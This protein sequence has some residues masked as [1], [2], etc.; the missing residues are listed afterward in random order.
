MFTLRTFAKIFAAAVC[1]IA[2]GAGFFLYSKR[3][4]LMQDAL[5]FAAEFASKNLGTTVTVGSANLD[6]I[7]LTSFKTS[8]LVLRDIKIF[9]KN[10]EP[11][12][13]VDEARLTFKLLALYYEGAAAID[14]VTVN[15]ARANI[16]KR[17]D[18]SWNFNDIK[19]KSS[20]GSNFDAFV[21]VTDANVHAEF[22]GK[23]VDVE[24]I[25]ATADCSD[26]DAIKTK[27]YATTLGANLDANA[28]LGL[29]RQIVNARV[30]FVD[31]LKILP[32]VP[33][34]II[35]DGVELLAGNVSGVTLN[36]LRTDTLSFSGSANF[37]DAAVNV[38]DTE[39]SNL[40]GTATFTDAQIFFNASAAANGQFADFNGNVRTDT[41]VPF[42][43]IRANSGS[44][45]PSAILAT[46]PIESLF[47]FDAH[48]VGTFDDPTV[49]AKI[50]SNA[51]IFENISASNFSANLK[52]QRN[53]V[54]LSD[55]RADSFGGTVNADC[56]FN[57]T[58]HALNAHL[59]ASGLSI[60]Q[61]KNLAE[62]DAN[63]SGSVNADLALNGSIDDLNSFKVF[64]AADATS[65]SYENFTVPAA[66]ASFAFADNLLTLDY[67]NMNLPDRGTVSAEGTVQDFSALDLNFHVSHINLALA[68][69]FAPDFVTLGGLADA[70]GTIKGNRSNPKIDIKLSAVDDTPRGFNGIIVNQRYD[71]IKLAASGNLDAVKVDDFELERDGKVVWT[72]IDGTVG[73]TGEKN[74]NL[75]LDTIGARTE[76]IVKVFAPDQ[77]LTGNIDN[78]IRVT[79]TLDKPH[80][81]GYLEFKYGSYRGFLVTDMRGDYFLDGNSLRLQDFV[82]IS[83]MVDMVLN[84]TIDVK[85]Y[86][87]NFTVVGRDINL[88]RFQAKFPNDYPVEGHGT[89]EGQISGNLDAPV[90][91]GKLA[92]NLLNFNGI[93][94]KNVNGHVTSNGSR[95]A[96][97]DFNFAQGS[98]RYQMKLTADTATKNLTG[99]ITVKNADIPALFALANKNSKILTGKLDSEITIGGTFDNPSGMLHGTISSG[100]VAGHDLHEVGVDINLLNRIVYVQKFAG[101]QGKTGEFN[102]SG[103]A[104]L[105]GPLNLNGTAQHIELA[106]LGDAAGLNADFT[107]LTNIRAKITGSV[108]NPEGEILLT[109]NGGIRGSTFDLLTAHLVLK[110]MIFDVQELTA[111]RTIDDK[112][113]HASARGT[114]PISALLVDSGERLS[115][116]EQLNLKVIL[117]DA[118]L[119][120]LPVVSDQIA[121]AVGK[122]GGTLTITGTASDPAVNGTIS[123][124][125]G[126]AKFKLV[127]SPVEHINISTTFSGNRFTVDN[128]T[129]SVGSGTFDLSG[130]LSFANYTVSDYN[131]TLTADN[132]DIRSKIFSGPF[133]AEF[134]LSEV[135]IFDKSFPKIAGVLDF[136]KC[137]VSVPAIPDSDAPL[138]PIL[139][140]ITINLGEKVHFY[141]SRLYNMYLTGSVKF[142]GIASH[143]K[144]SG[145]IS[146]KRGGTV[147]YIQNVFDIREGEAHFNQMGSFLPTIHF[148]ADSKV[149]NVKVDLTIDGAIG[150]DKKLPK[151]NLSSTPE[152]SETEIAQLLTLRDAY[153]NNTDNMSA[154]DILAL[155]LQM[156]ILGDIED[157]VKRTLNL[158]T[159]TFAAGSGSAFLS[160]ENEHNNEFHITASKYLNE[161]FAVKLSQGINGDTITRYGMQYDFND[162]FGFTAE[163]EANVY[164][165]RVEARYKF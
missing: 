154:T 162:N 148:V 91:D 34:D 121:W 126:S 54:F 63:I 105:N 33:A 156:S 50:S 136:D 47:A 38:L 93:E 76:D 160:D 21:K 16:V 140:D 141:S 118:D 123:V 5:N 51:I 145:I 4:A 75:R 163:R 40:T 120:L 45:K 137:T 74:I 83:P 132:L 125:D 30:D 116:S 10:S 133:N 165:F 39:V 131:F 85:T 89:F 142:E 103:T 88:K 129:G 60:A 82:I 147:T 14:T 149:S 97:E 106:M 151:I 27:I 130:A 119:S 155:G 72:V 69:N 67:L 56:E 57:A 17:A 115:A 114:V 26:L 42:F 107:G 90:F 68:Q 81:V 15:G 3:N 25:S 152:M 161:K 49:Y 12:A 110:D 102:I 48:L 23:S 43:D 143:P 135:K 159:F 28:V 58:S 65:L 41:D 80:V 92:A 11:I 59:I 113:Y 32:F 7:S 134:N 35:P 9:D 84:G 37:S 139:M 78:T 157:S 71:S 128:F 111:R 98:G 101:K 79:G 164:I 86:A 77:Q 127:E 31:L 70:F 46:F 64:G 96:L 87:M 6:N 8:E 13:A 112:I 99:T 55:I 138:P 117:D 158:D 18:K 24:N 153:G 29:N 1:I 122:M 53:A 22:D 104:S 52:Y 73:L 109:A 36:V 95:L 94:M 66:K 62:L 20:G 146:V 2:I 144:P 61:L 100:A 44:F 150:S 124:L 19:P 108:D